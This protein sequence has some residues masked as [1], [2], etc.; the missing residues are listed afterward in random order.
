MLCSSTYHTTR[1]IKWMSCQRDDCPLSPMSAS[2]WPTSSRLPVILLQGRKIVPHKVSW[3][4]ISVRI[5]IQILLVFDL[6]IKPTLL[7]IDSLDLCGHLSIPPL[8][9]DFLLDPFRNDFLVLVYGKNCRAIL[10]TLIIALSIESCR[11]MSPEEELENLSVGYLVRIVWNIERLCVCWW[12]SASVAVDQFKIPCIGRGHVRSPRLPRQTSLYVVSLLLP[13]AYPTRA[14]YN[15]FPLNSLRKMC[16]VPQKQPEATMALSAPSGMFT[17]APASPAATDI[18]E[19]A[20]NGLMRRDM[21][22][23]IVKAM[24]RTRINIKMVDGRNWGRFALLGDD[25]WCCLWSRR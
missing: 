25:S 15:P 20:R 10:T 22:E 6:A 4:L 7:W 14:S 17:D 13:P 8:G 24:R 5:D 9:I 2:G 1:P 19:Y 18:W 23:G 11:V 16:S 12:L 3:T 21:K